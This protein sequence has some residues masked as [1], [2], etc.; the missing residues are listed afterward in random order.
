MLQG[1]EKA[2]KREMR[3]FGVS[4]LVM[5]V[6]CATLVLVAGFERAE[7]K[8]PEASFGASVSASA[9]VEVIAD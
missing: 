4:G 5:V 7:A 3:V 9:V 8:I 2:M 1:K 6:L